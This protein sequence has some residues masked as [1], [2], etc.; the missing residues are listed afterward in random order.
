MLSSPA[1]NLES[2]IVLKDTPF[3]HNLQITSPIQP[4]IPFEADKR[5]IEGI[6]A[7]GGGYDM[8]SIS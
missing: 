3:A 6:K 7:L 5:I 4:Q 2:G 1:T 8:K